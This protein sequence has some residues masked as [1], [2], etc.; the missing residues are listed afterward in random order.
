[1]HGRREGG[2]VAANAPPFSINLLKIGADCPYINLYSYTIDNRNN[3][4]WKLL[5]YPFHTLSARSQ[6]NES[7]LNA[8]L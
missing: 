2:G 5:S 8:S 6:I 4:G 1:M 3:T 7:I